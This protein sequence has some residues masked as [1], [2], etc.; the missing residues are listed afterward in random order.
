MTLLWPM[1]LACL[2]IMPVALGR[3]LLDLRTDNGSVVWSEGGSTDLWRRERPHMVVD[4]D[5][6]PLGVKTHLQCFAMPFYT[7]NDHFTKTGSGQTYVGKALKRDDAFS[8]SD[9]F[10]TGS[11][12]A[13]TQGRARQRT[14]DRGRSCSP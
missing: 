3:F 8:D 11:R 12:S 6:A 2:N 10:R 14:I 5:G 7:K 9:R 4:N 13:R 1:H